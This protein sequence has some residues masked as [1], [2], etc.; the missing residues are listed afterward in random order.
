M[1]PTQQIY[2][3]MLKRLE[4]EN[5]NTDQLVLSK[6]Q[7]LG[8][9]TI[10]LIPNLGSIIYFVGLWVVLLAILTLL[11]VTTKYCH[12]S[13]RC[14][15]KLK[16]HV[17]WNMP[18]SF[19]NDVFIVAVM[20]C[21]INIFHASWGIPES[22]LNSTLAYI[23]LVCL[24]L[25]PIGVQCFLYKRRSSLRKRSFKRKFK[26]AYLYLSTKDQK[27]LVYPLF[28]FYRR[29]ILAF[30]LMLFYESLI[31]QY[32]TMMLTGGATMILILAT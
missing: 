26:N 22:I 6:F 16:G 18:I 2:H 8:F 13:D 12:N 30:V 3:K 15:K 21:L 10:W 27:Y 19:I 28:F 24:T 14:R 5:W 7:N 1:I 17:F 9:E 4:K 20:C 25:Y 23:I 29:L 11:A 32:L 31:T